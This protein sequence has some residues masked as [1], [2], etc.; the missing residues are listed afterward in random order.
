MLFSLHYCILSSS[1]LKTVTEGL[2]M[3][4]YIL[5][6]TIESYNHSVQCSVLETTFEIPRMTVVSDYKTSLSCIFGGRYL[7]F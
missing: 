6:I 4:A 2:K 5:F 3:A 1:F 7:V